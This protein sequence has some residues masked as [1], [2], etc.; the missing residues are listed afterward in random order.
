MKI[1]LPDEIYGI[2]SY[3]VGEGNVDLKFS[4]ILLNIDFFQ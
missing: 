1:I 4:K 3:F 2:V